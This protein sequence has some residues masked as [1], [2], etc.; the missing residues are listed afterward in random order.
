MPGWMSRAAKSDA[1][2]GANG[3]IIRMGWLGYFDGSSC[4]HAGVKAPATLAVRPAITVRLSIFMVSSTRLS[5]HF[6][7]PGKGGAGYSFIVQREALGM[8][9]PPTDR[10]GARPA[11]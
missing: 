2:P 7:G 5:P 6:V 11:S 10:G 3:T 8:R 4:A 9:A 1:P